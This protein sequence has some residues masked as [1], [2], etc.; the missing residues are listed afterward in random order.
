MSFRYTSEVVGLGD[1]ATGSPGKI[2]GRACIQLAD[3]NAAVIFKGE[4]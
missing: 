4:D 1:V 3:V 2:R